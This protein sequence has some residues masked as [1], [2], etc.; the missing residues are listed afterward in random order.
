[1]KDINAFILAGGKSSRMGSEK[2]LVLLDDKTFVKHII[3]VLVK[4]D[5]PINIISNTNCYDSYGY[6][7]FS[8]IIKDKGPLSG[9]HTALMNSDKKYNLILS[10]DIPFINEEAINYLMNKVLGVEDCIAP[11]HDGC[12]EPLCAIY[13]KECV[14]VLENLLGV[15]QLSVRE[16][17]NNINTQFVDVS[18]QD[19]YLDNLFMNINSKEELEKVNEVNLRK[20]D[21]HEIDWLEGF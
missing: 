10:C 14:S 11:T 9:I 20:N 12:S 19:F 16:A 17:L 6:P 5:L 3:D 21:V 7:V 4:L 8:D 1:M 13:S 2:G 18:H 15:N